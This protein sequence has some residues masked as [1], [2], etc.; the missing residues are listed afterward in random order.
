MGSVHLHINERVVRTANLFLLLMHG[1][2]CEHFFSRT[3]RAAIVYYII[4]W[5][6]CIR[7]SMLVFS[8]GNC[9]VWIQFVYAVIVD[10]QFLNP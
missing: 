4:I 3:R 1:P 2:R 7:G 8:T 9:T 10:Y 5:E 6:P